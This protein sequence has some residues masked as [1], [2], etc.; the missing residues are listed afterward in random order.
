MNERIAQWLTRVVGTMWCAYG[1]LALAT[2]PIVVPAWT[3][4]V[5]FI[6]S[7]VLQ[8]VLLPVIMVG[9]AVQNRSADR[10]EALL[11]KLVEELCAN[12]NLPVP[13]AGTPTTE[14]VV[15]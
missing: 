15:Q 5:Q 10:R 8:L 13:D 12:E 9:Q 2:V 1:F 3:P 6:S 4:V 11:L 7:G 14:G